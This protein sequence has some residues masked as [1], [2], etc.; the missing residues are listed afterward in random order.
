[1]YFLE[2]SG[3]TN[4]V[5]LWTGVEHKYAKL[6]VICVAVLM[7]GFSAYAVG[8]LTNRRSVGTAPSL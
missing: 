1:L 4:I 2:S 6:L 3:Y 7:V 8:I 5:G